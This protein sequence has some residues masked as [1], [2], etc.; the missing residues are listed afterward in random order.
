[1]G[2]DGRPGFARIHAQHP[3]NPGRFRCLQGGKWCLRSRSRSR[4][5]SS[6]RSPQMSHTPKPP[7]SPQDCPKP[8][9]G[10]T[11][12]TLCALSACSRAPPPPPRPLLSL[13]LCPLSPS[14]L[15]LPAGPP[16][17]LLPP[18]R[19][20][21]LPDQPLTPHAA[22]WACPVPCCLFL[23]IADPARHPEGR[24]RSAL[25]LCLRAR[26]RGREDFASPCTLRRAAGKGAIAEFSLVCARFRFLSTATSSVSLRRSSARTQCPA[27]KG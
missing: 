8:L 5:R 17:S 16:R 24:S 25:R 23:A 26:A 10:L 7:S 3:M 19:P 14:S 15:C 21:A 18:L 1:M 13:F 12:A 6:S 22:F 9:M 2:K 4:S 11:A 20:R 27:P